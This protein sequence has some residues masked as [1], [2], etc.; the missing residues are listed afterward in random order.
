MQTTQKIISRSSELRI[1]QFNKFLCV[2]QLL[3][4]SYMISLKYV[5]LIN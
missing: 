5:Q 2:N 1:A 4:I 3:L